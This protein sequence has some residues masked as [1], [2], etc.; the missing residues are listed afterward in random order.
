MQ[1]ST[2]H[3]YAK[4]MLEVKS[5]LLSSQKLC[6]IIMLFF[7]FFE[8]RTFFSFCKKKLISDLAKLNISTWCIKICSM[9]NCKWADSGTALRC[10]VSLTQNRSLCWRA[11]KTAAGASPEDY[12][13]K[14]VQKSAFQEAH[15][16]FERQ[17]Y[18]WLMQWGKWKA[19]L[20]CKGWKLNATQMPFCLMTITRFGKNHA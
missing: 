16:Q 14:F 15:R 5:N 2:R 17:N 10:V 7:F 12:F 13:L 19:P 6:R 1:Q 18:K 11:G 3:I 20:I 9:Q 4:I 8:V